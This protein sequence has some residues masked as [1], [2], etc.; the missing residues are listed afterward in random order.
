[1]FCGHVKNSRL[2]QLSPNLA[3]PKPPTAGKE[4]K[5]CSKKTGRVT[6]DESGRQ[7]VSTKTGDT[8]KLSADGQTE[9]QEQS[10][11]SL[12]AGKCR[13]LYRIF[14][15]LVIRFGYGLQAGHMACRRIAP[16]RISG[17]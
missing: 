2:P 16:N 7:V 5:D 8:T 10:C 12:A 13:I 4:T 14:N 11:L 6:P 1:M 17:Q 9:S 3:Q 15:Y